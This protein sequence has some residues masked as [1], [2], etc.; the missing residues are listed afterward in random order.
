MFPTRTS[1]RASALSSLAGRQRTVSKGIATTLR[2]VR[3]SPGMMAGGLLLLVM[4][5]GAVAAPVLVRYDPIVCNPSERMLPLE[6][7]HL[8]G[9]D[10]FG[11]DVLTRILFGGRISL[12][13]GAVAVS[14]AI[15]IGV[16]LG[17]LSGFYGGLV[18]RGVM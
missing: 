9:T 11:R 12:R 2:R 8:L 16:P 7:R 15:A 13:T 3:R 5:V 17:L 10:E 18:D 1:I 4:V 14:L 6:G